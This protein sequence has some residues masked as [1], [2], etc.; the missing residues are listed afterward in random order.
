MFDNK[1]RY[2]WSLLG[3]NRVSWSRHAIL[4][5]GDIFIS[6]HFL[7]LCVS[8]SIW[9]ECLFSFDMNTKLI[10]LFFIPLNCQ[11]NNNEMNTALLCIMNKHI[12]QDKTLTFF[13]F[14]P[15]SILETP[16]I[17]YTS[18]QSKSKK[19]KRSRHAICILCLYFVFVLMMILWCLMFFSILW[20]PPLIP[21]LVMNRE[22][23]FGVQSH[24][25]G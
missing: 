20:W 4:H 23:S 6:S 7:A 3:E 17:F 11:H 14:L 12:R 25:T 18:F 16:S 21:F 2:L 22:Q 5:P 19:K 9:I 10:A 24:L 1:I 8:A 13:S 15:S